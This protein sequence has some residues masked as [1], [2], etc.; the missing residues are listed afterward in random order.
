MA[1]RVL[2]FARANPPAEPGHQA[3]TTRF[4]ER[5]VLAD[6]LLDRQA[7]GQLT[8]KATR[9]KRR[10]LRRAI[11]RQYLRHLVSVAALAAKEDPNRFGLFV[12]PSGNLS[13]LAFVAKVRSMLDPAKVAAEALKPLGLGD[14]LLAELERVLDE[15]EG[16]ASAASEARASHVAATRDLDR[17]SVELSESVAVLDGIYRYRFR[18]DPDRLAQWENV[19]TMVRSP[20]AKAGPPPLEGGVDRAA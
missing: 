9:A 20:K 17:L 15:F 6:T 19:R 2:V 1:G 16:L 12:R 3:A 10:A 11:D 4:E 5:L 13:N 8:A 7:N 18:N 14:T